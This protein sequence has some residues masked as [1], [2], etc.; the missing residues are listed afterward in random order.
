MRKYPLLIVLLAS[1]AL[2]AWAQDSDPVVSTTPDENEPLPTD[3]VVFAEL[4]RAPVDTDVPPV[5]QL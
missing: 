1:T 2:P 4:I 3:I 5:E